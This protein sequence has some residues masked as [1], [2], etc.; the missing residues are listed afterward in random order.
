[1]TPAAD[2]LRVA[3]GN[4]LEHRRLPGDVEVVRPLAQTGVDERPRSLGEGAGAAQYDPNAGKIDRV[5]PVERERA[6]GET[7]LAREGRDRRLV[8]GRQNRP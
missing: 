8:T 2:R 6:V 3:R 4:A 1:M 7:Q 5:G